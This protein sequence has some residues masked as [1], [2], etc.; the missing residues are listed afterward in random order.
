MVLTILFGAWSI[1]FN[2]TAPALATML[3]VNREELPRL[4]PTGLDLAGVQAEET[5]LSDGQKVFQVRGI[6]VN[7]TDKSFRNITI[8]GKLFDS[9]NRTV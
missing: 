4:A 1:V 2:D 8:E 9:Q 5:T 7:A 6:V 3:G